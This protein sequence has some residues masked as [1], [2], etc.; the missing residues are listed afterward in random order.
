MRFLR[1]ARP[2]DRSAAAL[3]FPARACY[4]GEKREMIA[5]KRM[6][7]CLAALLCLAGALLAAAPAEA[8]MVTARGQGADERS[9][10]HAAMRAAVEQEVGVY[11]DSRTRVENYRLL[12]DSVYTKSEGFI[13]RYEVLAHDVLGGVHTVTI[14]ADVATERLRAGALSRLEKQALIGA[15]LEDPR[16]GVLAV[17][18]AGKTYPALENALAAALAREGFSRLIDLGQADA[19]RQAA[20]AAD[21]AEDAAARTAARAGTGCDYLAVVH[22]ARSAESLDAVLPGLH[23]VYLTAATRLINT[24]TGEITW[25]G[26]ADTASSHW[27]AGAE[28]EAIAAAAQKLARPL[29]R[30]ALKK[31]ATP[32]QHVRLT[33]PV[34]LLGGTA[35]ARERLAALPGVAHVYVRGITAGRLTADLDYD[36]TAA[37]LAA[38]LE[39]AGYTVRSFSSEAVVL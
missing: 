12:S 16:I 33:A 13:D 18:D 15:N 4:D 19:A 21:D 30:A 39:R 2:A 14:R 10:L 23:K 29:A 8:A 32:E 37:D 31:A 38:A 5:M 7:K 3:P 25:A 26:T 1:Q 9:A 20:L 22:V 28:G 27:Y 36:G 11:V 34:S 17:D 6:G 35:D 24:S